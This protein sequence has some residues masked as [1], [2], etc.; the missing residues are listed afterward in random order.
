M[1]GVALVD[2]NEISFF[3][4]FFS[5]FSFFSFFF[6]FPPILSH[7]TLFPTHPLLLVLSH[8][9][10]GRVLG[11][12]L[13]VPSPSSQLT[14]ATITGMHRYAHL[15]VGFFLERNDARMP[16]PLCGEQMTTLD[17]S[18]SFLLVRR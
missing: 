9:L 18:P 12:V 14:R 15:S 6:S 3:S 4:L 1:Y 17:A 11:H 2:L 10:S 5:S 8:P 7:L 13:V 16:Q